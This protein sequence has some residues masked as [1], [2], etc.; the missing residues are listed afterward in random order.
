MTCKYATGDDPLVIRVFAA[1]DGTQ[2]GYW[3][4]AGSVYTYISQVINPSDDNKDKTKTN[5]ILYNVCQDDMSTQAIV[6]RANEPD[7]IDKAYERYQ[8]AIKEWQDA[9]K[10]VSDAEKAY[11]ADPSP[12]NKLTLDNAKS[13]KV[14]KKAAKDRAFQIWTNAKNHRDSETRRENNRQRSSVA[15]RGSGGGGGKTP[16][17]IGPEIHQYKYNLPVVQSARFATGSQT[18]TDLGPQQGVNTTTLEGITAASNYQR[19]QTSG[20]PSPQAQSAGK[21]IA[22]GSW[23]KTGK[24]M[25]EGARR[26]KGVIQVSRDMASYKAPKGMQV[27]PTKWGFRFHYNPSS[28]SMTWGTSSEVDWSFEGSGADKA[29]PVALGLIQSTVSFSVLLNRIEDFRFIDANGLKDASNNPYL[30]VKMDKSRLAELKEIYKRGTMYDLDYLFKTIMAPAGTF[31]ATVLNMKT[32]DR[33]WLNPQPVELHLG[34]GLR[35]KVRITDM[36]VNHAMFN[37]RMVPVLSTVNITCT[38]YYDGMASDWAMDS[39]Q[40]NK[41]HA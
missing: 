13:E 34:D 24:A 20:V 26:G 16:P 25:W 18:T 5:R 4:K 2:G 40:A 14:A 36:S 28:V 23:S 29:N 7:A 35:F 21:D 27:D 6:D 11:K 9:C 41:S 32:A 22:D 8:T 17:S 31:K 10:A 12:A 33:G 39:G 3:S 38:R 1:G 15:N 30:P 37:D 19:Y